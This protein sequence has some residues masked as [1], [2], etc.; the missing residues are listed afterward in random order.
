MTCCDQLQ[1][2]VR[3]AK[4]SFGVFFVLEQGLYEAIEKR[5]SYPKDAVQCV[6]AG[7]ILTKES[8]DRE[9][10]AAFNTKQH[11]QARYRPF[12]RLPHPIGLHLTWDTGTLLW[13]LT[14]EVIHNISFG[15]LPD[16]WKRGKITA[17]VNDIQQELSRCFVYE[18]KDQFAACGWKCVVEVKQL[19]DARNTRHIIENSPGEIDVLAV[20]PD[21][22]TIAQVE[23]KRVS[24]SNDTR[25]YHDDL[26]DFYGSGKFVEKA[27]RKHAWLM[28]N[29]AVVVH[30]LKCSTGIEVSDNAKIH[31]LFLTLY[32]NF[33]MTR[34]SEVPILPAQ[35]FFQE[36]S[37]DALFWPSATQQ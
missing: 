24:P 17:A 26:S 12:A 18:V 29:H 8:L 11:F 23:C 16:E 28:E 31:P 19:R 32:P 14:N 35:I 15:K 4:N 1:H 9:K 20:S 6:M 7:L 30:H 25:T 10:R 22:Q 5:C 21:G 27:K 37:R 2:F 13:V 36:L 3:A 34:A 33:A